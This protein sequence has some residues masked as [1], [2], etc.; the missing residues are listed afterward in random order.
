MIMKYLIRDNKNI[1]ILESS[2]ILEQYNS[3]ITLSKLT[4]TITHISPFN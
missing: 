1:L 2:H 3:N 4:N